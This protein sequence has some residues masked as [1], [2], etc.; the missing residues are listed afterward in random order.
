[1]TARP[2]LDSTFVADALRNV[3]AGQDGPARAFQRAVIDSRDVEAGDL[4]VALPGERTDGHDFALDAAQRGAT[5]LLLARPVEG[6]S[7]VACFFVGGLIRDVLANRTPIILK[8]EVY[9]IAALIGAALFV[10]L[11]QFDLPAGLDLWGSIAVALAIR[12][13]ALA[14][15][16]SIPTFKVEPTEPE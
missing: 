10:L 1:M 16:W 11:R 3:L 4:F 5:G 13:A 7:N 6:A 8:R 14:M 9:A 15:R 12:L 2:A